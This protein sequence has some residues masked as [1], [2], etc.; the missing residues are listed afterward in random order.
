MKKGIKTLALLLSLV[1]VMG[2]FAACGETTPTETQ[3]QQTEPEKA[4]E[5]VLYWNNT[6]GTARKVT[7]G[8]AKFNLTFKTRAQQRSV[9]EAALTKLDSL[10]LFAVETDANA[11][12]TGVKTIEEIGAS[13]FANRETVVK[14][15]GDKVTVG[16]SGEFTMTK[17]TVVYDVSNDQFTM[18]NEN[19]LRVGDQV[20]VIQNNLKEITHVW[21]IKHQKVTLTQKC[22]HCDKDV[23]FTAWWNPTKMPNAA[24][25]WYLATNINANT[26]TLAKSAD[27]VVDLHGVTVKGAAN[28]RI[29]STT[30]K[31][32]SKISIMDLSEGA[33]GQIVVDDVAPITSAGGAFYILEGCVLNLYSGTITAE[34]AINRDNGTALHFN[35]GTFNMYG[36]KVIG[37]WAKGND[38]DDGS[39]MQGGYGGTV[40]ATASTIN[41]H[42]GEIVGGKATAAA[43]DLSCGRGKGGCM[44]ITGAS[45]FT[46]DGGKISGGTA[47][48]WGQCIGFGSTS[49]KVNI[50]EGITVQYEF[51]PK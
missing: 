13:Y 44:Y 49:V 37:G 17:K 21:I 7:D 14:V 24:G 48:Q 47:D 46:M 10:D 1:M 36:G 33:K 41:I 16:A 40:Y 2:L 23:A 39:G 4:I 45:S 43:A 35:K 34:K 29:I 42:G 18:G 12:I 26:V 6:R 15:D 30:A 11:V 8:I 3:P 50:A 19:T 38:K 20:I 28:A 31:N 32:N 22:P 5:Y 27:V 25:H 51:P 9:A